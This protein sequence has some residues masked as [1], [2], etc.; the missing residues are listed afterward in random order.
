MPYT[1]IKVKNGFKVCKE[2]SKPLECY[3]NKPLTKKKAMK[4]RIAIQI[5]EGGFRPSETV[6][7][8]KRK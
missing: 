8:K 4:Q 3:S 7:K 5:S 6:S 2:G 1:I